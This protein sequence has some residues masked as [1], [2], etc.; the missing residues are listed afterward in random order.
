MR[1]GLEIVIDLGVAGAAG[2]WNI[3]LERWAGRVFMAEDVVRSVAALAVRGNQQSFLAQREAVNRIHVVRED[4]GQALFRCHRAITVTLSAG[5]WD[6][7]RVDRR[8]GVC[9]R[10]DFV[11]IAVTARAGVLFR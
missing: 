9:L 1:A 8:T 5:L 3:R 2:F 11:R 7:Q 10:E 6:I 4:A